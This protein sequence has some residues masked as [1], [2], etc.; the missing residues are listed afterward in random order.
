MN[1]EIMHWLAAQIDL[2]MHMVL[3]YDPN[4]YGSDREKQPKNVNCIQVITF[5]ILKKFDMYTNC[6][7]LD[8]FFEMF[9]IN[10]ADASLA[11]QT[12]YVRIVFVS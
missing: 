9:M 5:W 12:I 3:L 7:D 4:L 2:Y 11:Q 10:L 6:L 8:K 1:Y